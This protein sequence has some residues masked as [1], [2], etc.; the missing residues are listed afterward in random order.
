MKHTAPKSDDWASCYSA[1]YNV[2][3][4]TVISICVNEMKTTVYDNVCR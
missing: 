1:N 3:Y 2:I 4:Y